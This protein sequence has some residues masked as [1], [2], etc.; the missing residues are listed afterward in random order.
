MA[1]VPLSDAVPAAVQ[2][3]QPSAPGHHAQYPYTLQRRVLE[4]LN[5][6]VPR[7]AAARHASRTSRR[8][9]NTSRTSG[10][11]HLVID[12]RRLPRGCAP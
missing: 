5:D 6:C 4:E 11:I 1:V 2:D 9:T 8:P 10:R 3:I 7:I 12:P